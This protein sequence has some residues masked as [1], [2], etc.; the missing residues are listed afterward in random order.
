[1]LSVQIFL[2]NNQFQAH[3][4]IAQR[5]NVLDP[6]G[7]LRFEGLDFPVQSITNLDKFVYQPRLKQQNIYAVEL[8]LSFFAATQPGQRRNDNQLVY[9]EALQRAGIKVLVWQ[10]DYSYLEYFREPGQSIQHR[11][12]DFSDLFSEETKPQVNIRSLKILACIIPNMDEIPSSG[13][14][15]Y[16]QLIDTRRKIFESLLDEPVRLGF[17]FRR[18]VD[19]FG[20]RLE[21]NDESSFGKVKAERFIEISQSVDQQYLKVYVQAELN[22]HMGS[23]IIQLNQKETAYNEYVLNEHDRV[24]C[25]PLKL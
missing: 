5:R 14:F 8:P 18:G 9:L 1:M 15:A 2:E 6:R 10:S 20:E 22:L 16:N 21:F 17:T 19:V 3:P 13:S 25:I 7:K 12:P 24:V 11:E 23:R 4:D